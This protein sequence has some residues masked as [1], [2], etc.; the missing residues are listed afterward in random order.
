MKNKFIYITSL[1]L[2]DLDEWLC[3]ADCSDNSLN[4]IC[5]VAD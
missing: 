2:V 4:L 3:M 1:Q 5:T